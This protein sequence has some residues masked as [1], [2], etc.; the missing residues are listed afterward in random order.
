MG[1]EDRDD[2]L[3]CEAIVITLQKYIQCVKPMIAQEQD[4]ARTILAAVER[5][6][7]GDFEL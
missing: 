7:R 1:D 4:Q 2:E 3:D 5:I 6:I